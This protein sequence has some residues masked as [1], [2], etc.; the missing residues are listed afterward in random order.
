MVVKIASGKLSILRER[1]RF[2]YSLSCR[3]CLRR[4]EFGGSSTGT[5]GSA[6]LCDLGA[7]LDG[8]RCL[9]LNTSSEMSI[10]LGSEPESKID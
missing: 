5:V 9:E 8:A 4:C 2:I 10:V 7:G 3:L 1:R 6:R